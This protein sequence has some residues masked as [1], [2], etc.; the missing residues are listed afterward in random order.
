MEFSG[1][2]DFDVLE[3]Q[4]VTLPKGYSPSMFAFKGYKAGLRPVD[5]IP[6]ASAFQKA[7]PPAPKPK[8]QATS[9]EGSAQATRDQQGRQHR[10]RRCR[11]GLSH[12]ALQ[13]LR[14]GTLSSLSGQGPHDPQHGGRGK[15]SRL[16]DLT[17][18]GILRINMPFPAPR[19]S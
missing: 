2:W 13:P 19:H 3:K 11:H 12:D 6:G 5:F 4:D 10:P 18:D 9:P 1:D 16:P 15:H 14:D 7:K 17:R 8:K